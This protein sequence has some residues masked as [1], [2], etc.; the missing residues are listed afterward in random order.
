MLE[1]GAPGQLDVVVDG[2]LVASRTDPALAARLGGLGGFPD[3]RK[4]IDLLRDRL[5][6]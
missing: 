6:G 3:P 5:A 1:R 4:V 2:E